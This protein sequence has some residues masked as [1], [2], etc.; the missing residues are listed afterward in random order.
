MTRMN[1]TGRALAAA[2]L[3][4]G[5]I[6]TVQSEV[7]LIDART[8]W[9]ACLVVGGNVVRD[10]GG[11]KLFQRRS[12]GAFDPA[13]AEPEKSGF[14][15]MPP[16]LRVRA[17]GPMSSSRENTTARSIAFSNSRTFPGHA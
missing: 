13:V 15:P 9:R 17:S 14:S 2:A 7:E 11:L 6:P 1:R 16:A 3:L 10:A 8:P 4:G 12:S 5:F